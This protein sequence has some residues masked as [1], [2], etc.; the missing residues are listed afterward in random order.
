M[1]NWFVLFYCTKP[2]INNF[3][4]FLKIKSFLQVKKKDSKAAIYLLNERN[5]NYKSEKKCPFAVDKKW[6]WPWSWFACFCSVHRTVWMALLNG[7]F[8]RKMNTKRSSSRSF[9][10]WWYC[11]KSLSLNRRRCSIINSHTKAA[12]APSPVRPKT[13]AQVTPRDTERENI[14]GTKLLTLAAPHC[15]KTT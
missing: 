7:P 10:Q 1:L 8:P 12:A 14:F 2:K 5:F 6:I 9:F 11:R 15:L 4:V 3:L 13:N